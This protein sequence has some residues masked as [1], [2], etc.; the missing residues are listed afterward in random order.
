MSIPSSRSDNLGPD[1][2]PAGVVPQPAT[3]AS[4]ASSASGAQ[5][6]L[7]VAWAAG[8]ADGECCIHVARQTY[9]CGRRDTHRLR[10]QIYQNDCEVLE[11]FRD[12]VGAS[13]RVYPVKRTPQHTRQVY[14]INLDGQEAMDVIALLTPH[15][16][17]KKA[18]ALAARTYWTEGEAGKHFGPN[19]MPPEIRAIR[20]RL[21]LEMRSLK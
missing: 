9:R 8:F 13:A 14:Q 18:E 10:L 4:R 20:E 6:Q 16:I 11:H 2:A 12:V 5:A 17:R 19:G 1:S 15:L 21:Y 7:S 3:V